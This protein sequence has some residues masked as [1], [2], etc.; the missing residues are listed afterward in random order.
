MEEK[1]EEKKC[2]AQVEVFS[3]CVGFFRPVQEWNKGKQQ[4]FFERLTYNV[5]TVSEIEAK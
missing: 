4:E 5:P 1:R 2:E 3:R